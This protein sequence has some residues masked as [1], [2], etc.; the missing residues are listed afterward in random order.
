MLN[1]YVHVPLAKLYMF[2][3]LWQIWGLCS[4][5][6]WFHARFLVFPPANLQDFIRKSTQL[7]LKPILL[8]S[9]GPNRTWENESSIIIYKTKFT[10]I[11]VISSYLTSRCCLGSFLPGLLCFSF[12]SFLNCRWSC[13]RIS[14][15]S[16]CS[17]RHTTNERN[18]LT[19]IQA[20][21]NHKILLD[22]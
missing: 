15:P 7:H 17:R 4:P 19:N 8:A 5:R 6:T 12:H 10:A 16:G 21:R 22:L 2:M 20:F 14:W 3:T 13:L 18:E 1:V 11:R 9:A